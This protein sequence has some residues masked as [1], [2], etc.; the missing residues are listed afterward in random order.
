MNKEKADRIID[1]MISTYSGEIL[2]GLEFDYIEYNEFVTEVQY[3]GHSGND[4]KREWY[5]VYFIDGR[6]MDIYF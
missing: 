3:N 2:S 5:T 1:E 6:E 4:P